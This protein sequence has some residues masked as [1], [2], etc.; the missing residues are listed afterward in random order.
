MA[1][2]K[3]T[4]VVSRPALSKQVPP[5]RLPTVDHVAFRFGRL[6]HDGPWPLCGI[7]TSA[8]R[9]VLETLGHIGASTFEELAGKNGNKGIPISNLGPK[10]RRRL[11]ELRLD[12]YEE[13]WEMRI[14]GKERVWGLRDGSVMMLLWW[15][16]NH[17]VCPSQKR[18]T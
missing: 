18:H 12:D 7:E 13:V 1:K 8:H 17:Q 3:R 10:A 15:D 4:S 5:P 6:D 2:T 9:R 16:P 14:N 11:G